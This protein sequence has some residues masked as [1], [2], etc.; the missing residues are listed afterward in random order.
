MVRR[1]YAPKAHGAWN[2]KR[3]CGA[4]RLE[5]CVLF[6]SVAALLGGVGQANYAAANCCLDSLSGSRRLHGL[7]ASS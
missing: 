1:V 2:L 6:S 7:P 5:A 3:A 4:L